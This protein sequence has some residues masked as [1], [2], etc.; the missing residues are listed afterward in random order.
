VPKHGTEAGWVADSPLPLD[1]YEVY[2]STIDDNLSTLNQKAIGSEG[3]K[4]DW[5]FYDK[6]AHTI[7]NDYP[8]AKALYEAEKWDELLKYIDK[9][10]LNKPVE[11]FTLEKLRKAINIDWRIGMKEIIEK[12]YANDYSFKTREERLD[13]E[14]DKF[15][16]RRMPDETWFD[17]AK[18][19]FKAY[20]DDAEF[21]D[22]VDRGDFSQLNVSPYGEAF[23]AL[24]Q[25]RRKTIVEYIKDF[26]SWNDFVN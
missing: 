23:R 4:V 2:N 3:M 20:I 21:R 7:K 26:V 8:V 10:V 16:S 11:F 14:F 5:M 15:D 12:I 13:E 24:S 19:V 6:F 22:I 25:E 17:S 18:T 9:N 1:Y